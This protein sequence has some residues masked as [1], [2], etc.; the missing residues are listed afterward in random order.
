MARIYNP[1]DRP[2]IDYED[3][4][5]VPRRV[6]ESKI[7]L[8]VI[9]VMSVVCLLAFLIILVRGSMPELT[10]EQIVQLDGYEGQQAPRYIF[11]LYSLK[12]QQ[13][14]EETAL[15][16]AAP[17]VESVVPVAVAVSSA[18]PVAE[19]A[20]A[21]IESTEI[22]VAPLGAAQQAEPAAVIDSNPVTVYE[23]A[24]LTR[25]PGRQVIGRV[26][27]VSRKNNPT[28]QGA[29]IEVLP[30]LSV[31]GDQS[32]LRSGPSREAD[33]VT[34]LAKGDTITV[35]DNQGEW[36]YVGTNDG[37]STIGYMH[38]SLLEAA[39]ATR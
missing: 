17:Q 30:V 26:D 10:P 22:R 14:N 11:N 33:I 2:D 28:E 3:L 13:A 32:L 35:F 9:T 37:S 31:V 5:E 27:A 24:E 23:I 20:D 15:P 4:Q 39:G 19:P 18:E 12:Q 6:R 25:D 7:R 29:V 21:V 38:N 8:V 16:K 34:T 1:N 36:S